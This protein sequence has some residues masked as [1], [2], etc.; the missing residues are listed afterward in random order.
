MKRL[1]GR[2]LSQLIEKKMSAAR[3]TRANRR[4]PTT[5]V[6][7]EKDENV[8]KGIRLAPVVVNEIQ[9]QLLIIRYVAILER[10]IADERGVSSYTSF[11]Q[12]MLSV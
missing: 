7:R 9:H 5:D 2:Q 12:M 4:S 1:L 3:L 8:F 6:R 10:S 11:V